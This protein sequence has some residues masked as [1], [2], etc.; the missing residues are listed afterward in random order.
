MG[1]TGLDRLREILD[2]RVFRSVI[3]ALIIINA[4]ILGALTYREMPDNWTNTLIMIDQCILA[5]FVGEILLKFVAYRLEFFKSGW[6]LFDFVVIAISLIP[7]GNGVTILRAMRVLRVL[8]L[9]RFVPMMRRITEALFRALP[10]MGAIIAILLLVIYVY[11]VMATTLFGNSQNEEVATL[12]GDLPSSALT[13]FQI[14]TL[15]GWRGEVVQKVIDD[16]HPWAGWF[17]IVFIFLVSFAIL[18]LFIAL[19]VDAL[20]ADHEQ[21]QEDRLAHLDVTVGEAHEEREEMMSILMGLRSELA[22][23]KAKLA[24]V[25]PNG[26]QR[27]ATTDQKDPVSPDA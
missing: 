15:D 1:S 13:M 2:G 11:A 14:M 6:N 27:T 12:F 7:G 16:G 17:F 8:R 20:Q 23:V 3:V 25:S 18:N 21:A 9:L 5:L 26:D 19:I 4:L 24:D 22:D 10:G